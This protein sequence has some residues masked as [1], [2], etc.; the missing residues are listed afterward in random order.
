MREVSDNGAPKMDVL[1]VIDSEIRILSERLGRYH[2]RAD[3]AWRRRG[4]RCSEADRLCD[5][6]Q[7][8]LE[9]LTKARADI[10]DLLQ[11]NQRWPS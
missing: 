11:A 3:K 4:V 1:R 6:A 9:A 7:M 8:R 2:Q 10:A 5:W